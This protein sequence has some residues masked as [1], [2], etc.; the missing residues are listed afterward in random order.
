MGVLNSSMDG[1]Y[2]SSQQVVMSE[3]LSK[4]PTD[5]TG[6][7][8]SSMHSHQIPPIIIIKSSSSKMGGR[9]RRCLHLWQWRR[10]WLHHINYKMLMF[11]I[12]YPLDHTEHRFLQRRLHHLPFCYQRPQLHQHCLFRIV[13]TPLIIRR[14]PL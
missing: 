6:G 7:L 3:V 8:L 12:Y 5:R 11:S 13:S 9:F 10:P 2:H 14:M 4:I 1:L